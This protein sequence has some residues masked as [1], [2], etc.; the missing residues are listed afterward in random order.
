MGCS[1]CCE[2]FFV[3]LEAEK[4]AHYEL[5]QRN[6]V[7]SKLGEDF[8]Y[9]GFDEAHEGGVKRKRDGDE[10]IESRDEDGDTQTENV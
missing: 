5:C 2:K 10:D 1:D 9:S 6:K 7:F 4:N 3:A 8:R